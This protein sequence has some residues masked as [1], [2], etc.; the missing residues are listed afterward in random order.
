MEQYSIL[1]ANI[2]KTSQL[3]KLFTFFAVS[4][5]LCITGLASASDD[6]QK[7]D[8]PSWAEVEIPSSWTI[9]TSPQS[10]DNQSS[11]T[12][13]SVSPDMNSELVYILDHSTEKLTTNGMQSFQDNW[14]K[15]AGFRICRTKDPEIRTKTDH[16]E[17]KQVYV[18]GTDKGAVMYS[19]SYPD[20]GQYH[21][22]LLMDGKSAVSQYYE[23]I[24]H[25]IPDH[26]LPI[27]KP[28]EINTEINSTEPNKS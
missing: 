12:I 7:V 5:L 10:W 11:V 25:Q 15:D 18:Q 21:V 1:S 14:M 22:A 2:P 20:W 9:T 28:V 19:A 23:I 24:P 17:V 3:L 4:T 8:S 13:R 16:T 26:I 6:W 27:I